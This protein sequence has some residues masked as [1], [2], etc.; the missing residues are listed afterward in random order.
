MKYDFLLF[1]YYRNIKILKMIPH[2]TVQQVQLAMIV[3]IQHLFKYGPVS[4]CAHILITCL[5]LSVM[6]ILVS[7]L[8]T[9][10]VDDTS[11]K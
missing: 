7:T 11:A 3:S 2:R 9:V 6:G 1:I 8:G 5:G 10:S 4:Q